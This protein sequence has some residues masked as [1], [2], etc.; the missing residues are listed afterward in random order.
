MATLQGPLSGEV[1]APDAIDA[2]GAAAWRALN[3]SSEALASPFLTLPYARA[4]QQAGRRVRVCVIRQ[5]GAP[6]GFF[7]FELDG[8][9]ALLAGAGSPLGGVMTDYVGLVAAPS[10]RLSA[11]QLLRLARL[12]TFTFSHLDESQ[13]AYGLDG[14]QPRLGL[15]LRIDPADPLAS[16]RAQHKYFKDSERCALK[17]AKEVGPLRFDYNRGEG[18]AALLEQLIVLKRGQYARTGVADPLAAPWAQALLRALAQST[19]PECTGVLST[20]HAGQTCVAAHFGL[21]SPQ[22]LHHWMPVYHADFS[23][24]APG[25]LLMHNMIEACSHSSIRMI[26]HGE[27]DSVSKRHVAN[28]EHPYYRGVWHDGSLASVATRGVQSLMWRLRS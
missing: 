20:L 5:D 4:V 26:D 19:A 28:E 13:L 10:L 12:S 27:G 3:A 14:E 21:S 16:V 8:A 25:R 18:R 15:R 17:L 6:V 22:V 11:R 1:L 9:G 2:A 7:P 24:Y 23:K